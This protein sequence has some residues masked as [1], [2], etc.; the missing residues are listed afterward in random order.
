MAEQRAITLRATDPEA[1]HLVEAAGLQARF[2]AIRAELEVPDEF[3]PEVLAEAEQVAADPI[4]LPERDETAV[5]FC[6]ID[7]PGSMDLDQA[8]HIERSDGGYRVRYAIAHLPSFVEPGG[9]VDAEAR[10]RGQTIYAPDRRTPL[11]PPVFSEGAASLL[12]DQVT[13]AYVWD[14]TLDERGECTDAQ[15]YPALVRSTDRFDYV[16]VQAAV[17]GGTDDERLV[18]LTEVGE[19]RVRLEQERGGASL[20][21]PDQQVEEVDGRYRLHLR[22]VVPSEEWNAQISLLTGMAAAD[23]ML[24]A[25]V[26]VLRTMPPP[27]AETLTTLRRVAQALG[28]PWPA[29]QTHGEMLRALDR[30]DPTH[31]ALIHEATTLFRGAGYV[32]FD[33]ELP[34]VVEQSAIAAPYT[35]VTAPLRRLV[36]RF[37]LALCAALSAGD[38]VPAWVREALPTLPELMES[39]DRIAGAVQRGTTDAVEAA[40]LVDRVGEVFTATVV[41]TQEGRDGDGVTVQLTD[42]VVIARASG[43]AEAGAQVAVRLGAVDLEAGTVTFEVVT[44]E[45]G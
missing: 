42:P 7:P 38:P 20:P 37:T 43:R 14:M 21:M 44:P 10:R 11:H 16:G 34:E 45:G 9:A 31:L 5:P 18:L 19:R 17:D 36:D 40:T 26:G 29:E 24:H 25:R 35:H 8:L 12:P 15:V 6:T 1:R 2:D 3:P 41:D 4:V 32:A 39:S 33:G 27:S 28:V 13:P 22:P 23:L 30:T